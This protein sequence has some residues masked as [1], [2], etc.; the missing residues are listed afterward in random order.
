MFLSF[1]SFFLF[2]SARD[3]RGLSADRRKTLPH[4]RKWMQ[5]W[6]LGPK[7]GGPPPKNGGGAKNML[8]GTISDDFHFDRE[9]LRILFCSIPDSGMEQDID[10]RKTALQTAISPASA[11]IIWWPLVHKRL[12]IEP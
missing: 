5:F 9:Y 2:Y 12:K 1:F 8:F 3:L 4:D 6:K 11:D 7:F 10:N